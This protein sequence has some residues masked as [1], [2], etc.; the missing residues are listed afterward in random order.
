MDGMNEMKGYVTTLVRELHERKG[1]ILKLNAEN[2]KKDFEIR[3]FI[4]NNMNGA[5]VEARLG[6]MGAA[7]F[8][9]ISYLSK[10]YTEII[11]YMEHWSVQLKNDW[12][13]VSAK[14]E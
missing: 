11:G 2:N 12:N 8:E 14:P 4:E 6:K 10:K 5:L 3:N 7:F 13:E 9:Q 1:M